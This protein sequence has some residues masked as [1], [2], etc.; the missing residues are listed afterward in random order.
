[1]FPDLSPRMEVR[2][3][4]DHKY[5]L[6][7]PDHHNTVLDTF[8]WEHE[9]IFSFFCGTFSQVD[10][11]IWGFHFSKTDFVELRVISSSNE[12][13][14]LFQEF[15]RGG[16][17][18]WCYFIMRGQPVHSAQSCPVRLQSLLQ[19]TS[20]GKK[21]FPEF[22]FVI[23]PYRFSFSTYLFSRKWNNLYSV[24]SILLISNN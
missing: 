22:F 19:K 10:F 23:I 7:W 3:S 12:S 20:K 1:M 18:H 9:D 6:R 17:F 24:V 13:F 4:P 11:L 21:T 15:E 5:S 14:L 16:G 2:P 8:R